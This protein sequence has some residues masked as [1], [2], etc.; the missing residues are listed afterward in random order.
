MLKNRGLWTLLGFS[1]VILG[2]TSL[3]MTLVG[4]N[5]A[6]LGFLEWGGRLFAFV[7]KILMVMAGGVIIALANNN[8]ERDRKESK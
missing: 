5:W 7:A 1:L 8:W 2:F 3:I 4:V 6:F